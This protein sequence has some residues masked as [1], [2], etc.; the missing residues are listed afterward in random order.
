MYGI[1][2]GLPW[3]RPAQT[4]PKDGSKGCD[5]GG[6]Y[7]DRGFGW[8]GE[9][10]VS[11]LQVCENGLNK[12]SVQEKQCDSGHT[13][14]SSLPARYVG[15]VPSGPP[16]NDGAPDVDVGRDEVGQASA[17]LEPNA[18]LQGVAFS[19]SRGLAVGSVPGISTG[20]SGLWGDIY[21]VLRLAPQMSPQR[22]WPS[23]CCPSRR[24]ALEGARARQHENLLA[25]AYGKQAQ[26]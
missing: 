5:F 19:D 13:P 2:S 25:H 9:A 21:P 3:K 7:P 23:R 11:S 18:E 22:C 24:E 1:V 16:L 15:T 8:S 20:N 14:V 17:A 4:R 12:L 26:P 6:W 10:P